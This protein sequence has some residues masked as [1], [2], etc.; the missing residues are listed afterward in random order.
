MLKILKKLIKTAQPNYKKYILVYQTSIYDGYD[1]IYCDEKEL[2]KKLRYRMLDYHIFLTK[3][4]LEI[5][6]EFKIE[7]E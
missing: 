2:T 4:E 5:K 6:T 1:F 7:V 3:D